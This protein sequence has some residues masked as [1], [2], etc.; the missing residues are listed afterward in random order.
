MELL[1]FSTWKFKAAGWDDPPEGE[2]RRRKGKEQDAMSA[3][4][5]A[6]Q[7]EEEDPVNEAEKE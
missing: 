1:A 4:T 5:V 7:G 3:P 2:G 6:G